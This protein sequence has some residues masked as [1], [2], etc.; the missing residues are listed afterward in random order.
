[1]MAARQ[2]L[3]NL[4]WSSSQCMS[5]DGHKAGIERGLGD[6]RRNWRERQTILILVLIFIDK[7]NNMN[8]VEQ[9]RPTLPSRRPEDRP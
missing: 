2:K 9:F 5:I 6:L 7:A 1:M 8:I 4:T 3:I